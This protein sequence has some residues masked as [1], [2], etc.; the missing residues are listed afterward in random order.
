MVSVELT[1]LENRQVSFA[2]EMTHLFTFKMATIRKV[3]SLLARCC[4]CLPTD[5][6]SELSKLK[7]FQM[8]K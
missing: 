2:F 5:K 4:N 1:I 7:H 3:D 8:T 6:I